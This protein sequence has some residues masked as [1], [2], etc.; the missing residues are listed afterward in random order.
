LSPGRA[1][2]A[3]VRSDA[4]R[5]EYRRTPALAWGILA[6]LLSLAAVALVTAASGCFGRF[7]TAA[8]PAA[9]RRRGG[10]A[11]TACAAV[12]WYVL[13]ILHGMPATACYTAL[14][15]R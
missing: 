12:A 1:V 10:C 6:A 11:R 8:A 3:F 4:F 2:Q 5:C 7:G 9:G 13:L 14:L 15:L